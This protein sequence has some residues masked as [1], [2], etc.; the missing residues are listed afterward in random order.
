LAGVPGCRIHEHQALF[1]A[2]KRPR[3]TSPLDRIQQQSANLLSLVDKH[4]QGDSN[5]LPLRGTQV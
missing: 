4:L 5:G 1:A 3:K 2:P